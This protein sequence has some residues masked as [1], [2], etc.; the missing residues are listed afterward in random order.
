MGPWE[1]EAGGRARRPAEESACR[2]S[3]ERVEVESMLGK[4]V[5]DMTQVCGEVGRLATARSF[6]MLTCSSYERLVAAHVAADTRDYLALHAAMSCM[7]STCC[8]NM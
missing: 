7:C 6:V 5:G 1:A 3:G 8:S 2:C 4:K